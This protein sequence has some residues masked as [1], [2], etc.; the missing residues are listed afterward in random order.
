MTEKERV[1]A[2]CGEIAHNQNGIDVLDV[3]PIGEGKDVIGYKIDA[4]DGCC[5][6]MYHYPQDHPVWPLAAQILGIGQ[7]KVPSLVDVDT[8]ARETFSR[9]DNRH[10]FDTGARWVLGQIKE[11]Q[12]PSND[13]LWEAWKEAAHAADWSQRVR[14]RETERFNEWLATLPA[15]PLEADRAN[16]ADAF[17]EGLEEDLVRNAY[18][19]E[20]ISSLKR[21]AGMEVANG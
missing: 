18:N 6:V 7:D 12:R 19:H 11:P 4:L 14:K 17:T 16:L 5:K 8:A 21:L 9:A 3:A 10:A 13:L 2:K 20:F 15:D 1:L